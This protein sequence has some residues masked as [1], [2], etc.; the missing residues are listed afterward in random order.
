MTDSVQVW[1][2]G[3]SIEIISFSLSRKIGFKKLLNPVLD[4]QY[5]LPE[6]FEL[7]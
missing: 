7:N 2:R 5:F 6:K 4:L 1:G 3:G